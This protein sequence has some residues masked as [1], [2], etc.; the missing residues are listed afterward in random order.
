[1]TDRE[2]YLRSA[3]AVPVVSVSTLNLML[4]NYKVYSH[5][6]AWFVIVMCQRAYTIIYLY[7]S[8]FVARY[9]IDH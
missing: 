9:G 2:R 6:V 8:M 5:N 1:M 7:S 3:L 4:K